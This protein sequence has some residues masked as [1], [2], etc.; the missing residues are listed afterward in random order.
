M[1]VL[2]VLTCVPPILLVPILKEGITVHV[3]LDIME[4]DTFVTVSSSIYFVSNP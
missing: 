4:M 2:L 3:I 1:S